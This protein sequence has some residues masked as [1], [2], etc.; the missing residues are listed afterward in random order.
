MTR[1]RAAEHEYLWQ[2]PQ[3]AHRQD[4]DSSR[5]LVAGAT[6]RMGAHTLNTNRAAPSLISVVVPVRDSERTLPDVLAALSRQTYK[7]SWEAIVVVDD[8]SRD[9]SAAI[10]RQWAH[11]EPRGRVTV[12]SG[13]AGGARVRN[14]G[15]R[16]THGDFIAFCD[17][18]DLPD[19]AWLSGLASVAPNA[20]LV[21]GLNEYER[22]NA[23]L[24]RS[25]H[26]ERPRDRPQVICGFLPLATGANGGIWREVFDALGGFDE[27]TVSGEDTDLSWRAQLLSYTLVFAPDARVH[28]RYRPTL[29]GLARQY[30]KY[31]KGNA[32]LFQRHA[33]AGMP[34]SRLG[35]G[36]RRWWLLLPLLLRL[37][38]DPSAR[39]RCVQLAALSAGRIVGSIQH[40]RLYL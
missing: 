15:A 25:W 31:G 24:V 13:G 7:G 38:S 10:A 4:F 16:A 18:D 20:D 34:P 30:Y 32:W 28:Y 37:R 12:A 26:P 36:L 6:C 33:R 5:A 39:G 29:R 27:S 14:V 3:V 40:R 11:R 9:G 17:A 8:A 22:L 2:E 23:P 19:D 1:E 35:A 21:A